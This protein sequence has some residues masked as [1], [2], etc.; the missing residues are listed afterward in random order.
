MIHKSKILLLVLF[1]AILLSGCFEVTTLIKVNKDGSGK[2]E[3][4]VFFDEEMMTGILAS[5][6]MEPDDSNKEQKNS[7]YDEEKL[8]S[9]IHRYGE[10]VSYVFS[11]PLKKEGKVGY[12]VVYAFEDITNLTVSDN[13][14]GSALGNNPMMGA[15]SDASAE[16]LRFEFKK[17]KTSELIIKY[18]KPQE[19]LDETGEDVPESENIEIKEAEIEQMKSMFSGMKFSM[20]FEFDGKITDT[21]ATHQDNSTITFVEVDF[22]KII[23]DTENLKKLNG[24]KDSQEDMKK[25]MKDF[26]GVKFEMCEE[27]QVKFK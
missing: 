27:L 8:K 5:F 20:K 25:V 10:N 9:D 6:G 22:D 19:E 26:P 24:V 23:N 11:R 18:P 21:N 12:H 16:N 1:V 15:M 17:G 13:P 3:E 4:T 7:F 2:L 14:V